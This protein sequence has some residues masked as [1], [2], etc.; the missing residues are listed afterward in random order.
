MS[1]RC[2]QVQ[3]SLWYALA[4]PWVMSLQKQIK[5]LR[6]VQK[7]VIKGMQVTSTWWKS[8][9]V[10]ERTKVLLDRIRLTLFDHST[11]QNLWENLKATIR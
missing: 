6:A 4:E 9:P 3:D 7:D 11:L 1:I 2:L 10:L 5:M 8:V